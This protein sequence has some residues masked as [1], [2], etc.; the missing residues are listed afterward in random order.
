MEIS[1]SFH[2]PKDT[3]KVGLKKEKFDG[4]YNRLRFFTF[5]TNLPIPT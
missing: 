3:L 5:G 2:F 4:N 1:G